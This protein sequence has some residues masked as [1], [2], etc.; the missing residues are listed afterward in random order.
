MSAARRFRARAHARRLNRTAST[1]ANALTTVLQI[2][3]V[4]LRAGPDRMLL[5][6]DTAHSL[7]A[8]LSQALAEGAPDA[9]LVTGDV[10][11]DPEPAA[12]ER[13]ASIVAEHF[14]GPMLCLPG[15]HDLGAPM[16]GL[17]SEP[18]VL[19]LGD[20]DVIGLDSHV[21]D[22]TEAGVS[23]EDLARL[24]ACLRDAGPRHVLIATHHPPVN[25]GCPWLDKDRIQNGP[26]LLESLSE[27]TSV[28]G[29]VFG[30][31]HQV[32]ESVH[33]DIVLLGTP[34]TC[35]QFAPNTQRFAIDDTMPGYRWLH[36]SAAGD[37]RSEVRRV[38]DYP[39]KI[40]LSDRPVK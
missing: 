29:M 22:M 20:W 23:E 31:A 11:H 19:H 3:D 24:H 13:F 8:V 39:L 9:L 5:G 4:H 37:V 26:E 27:H 10:S 36:L 33:K 32:V 7:R 17:L 30:H 25:V 34:S 40:D 2:T 16:R 12:Y 38:A 14:Q 21:D 28:K 35:F 15:N 1:T 18:C 6:V